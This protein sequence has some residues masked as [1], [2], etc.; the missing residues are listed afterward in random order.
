MKNDVL[1]GGNEDSAFII[2]KHQGVIRTTRPLV[3]DDINLYQFL[4]IFIDLLLKRRFK[5]LKQTAFKD[6][7]SIYRKSLNLIQAEFIINTAQKK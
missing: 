5:I 7:R 2:S 3:R 4:L 6:L 1:A